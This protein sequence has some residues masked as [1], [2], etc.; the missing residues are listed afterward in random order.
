M[1]DALNASASGLEAAGALLSTAA[2]NLANLNTAGYQSQSVNLGEA[3]GAAGSGVDIVDITSLP[4][5]AGASETSNVDPALQA[6]NLQ[7]AKLLYGV[8]GAAIRVQNR[9]FGSLIDML[10]HEK[11]HPADQSTDSQP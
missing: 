3:P 6:I 9:A 8:N 7:K 2:R 4:S 11:K 1:F 10:D 5:A